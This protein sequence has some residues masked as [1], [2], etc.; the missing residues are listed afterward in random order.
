MAEGGWV[1]DG[2]GS[3]SYNVTYETYVRH[4]CHDFGKMNFSKRKKVYTYFL[5]IVYNY[6]LL[7]LFNRELNNIYYLLT[8]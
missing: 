1:G 3:P 4:D 8:Y 6:V 5:G 2:L 7:Y